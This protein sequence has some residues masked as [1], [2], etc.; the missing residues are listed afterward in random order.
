MK[1]VGH[2]MGPLTAAIFS[3][4][5]KIH[6]LVPN[7]RVV[8][9]QHPEPRASAEADPSPANSSKLSGQRA[10]APALGATFAMLAYSLARVTTNFA[11]PGSLG[12][13]QGNPTARI[14]ARGGSRCRLGRENQS[15]T[16]H[17]ITTAPHHLSPRNS[18]FNFG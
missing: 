16:S 13:D 18:K 2:D 5:V 12:E 15:P 9:R 17:R 8:P 6:A 7:V 10:P 4:N 3:L 14:W 1:D 11:R